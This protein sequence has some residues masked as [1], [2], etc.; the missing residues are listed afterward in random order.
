MLW[1]DVWMFLGLL[2]MDSDRINECLNF[3]QTNEIRGQF[4]GLTSQGNIFGKQL[5][6]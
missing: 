6:L 4:H 1:H 2:Q 5:T 3:K